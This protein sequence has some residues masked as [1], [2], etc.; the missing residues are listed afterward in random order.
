M[1][2]FSGRLSGRL[3]GSAVGILCNLKGCLSES[4]VEFLVSMAQTATSLC[5]ILICAWLGCELF[6]ESAHEKLLHS[7]TKLDTL[8]LRV[9][10]RTTFFL[11]RDSRLLC[12]VSL[13]R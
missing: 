12:A 6:W 11:G 5:Q 8:R 13:C 10:F 1:G 4:A 9:P 3:S 7:R 2:A